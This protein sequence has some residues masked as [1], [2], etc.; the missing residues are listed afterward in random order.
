MQPS[1][2]TNKTYPLTQERRAHLYQILNDFDED[3]LRSILTNH[4]QDSSTPNQFQYFTLVQLFQ[5]CLALIDNCYSTDLEQTLYAMRQKRFASDF[6]QQQQSYYFPQQTGQFNTQPNYR[7]SSP[8]SAI[9]QQL[10]ASK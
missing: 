6:Y 10:R 2:N 9:T 7:F 8:S 1:S 5:Q 4:S 3:Q